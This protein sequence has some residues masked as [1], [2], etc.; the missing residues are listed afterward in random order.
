MEAMSKDQPDTPQIPHLEALIAA[1]DVRPGDGS[2]HLPEPV[3]L[4]GDGRTAADQVA[5][6]RR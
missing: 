4:S 5:E 3:K 6:D 1:G 2:R